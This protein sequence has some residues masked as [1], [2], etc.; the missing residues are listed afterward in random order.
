MLNRT[1][2]SMQTKNKTGS[3]L[4]IPTQNVGKGLLELI[5]QKPTLFQIEWRAAGIS[6]GF[7]SDDAGSNFSSG[8]S[9]LYCLHWLP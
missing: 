3:Q 2:V 9:E 4:G 8:L 1:L 5:N 6:A 7:K